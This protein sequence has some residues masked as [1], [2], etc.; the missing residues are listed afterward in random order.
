MWKQVNIM[1][2]MFKNM[3]EII[4]DCRFLH[5]S[6]FLDPNVDVVECSILASVAMLGR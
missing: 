3:V 5:P 4:G 2:R 1:V 6:S